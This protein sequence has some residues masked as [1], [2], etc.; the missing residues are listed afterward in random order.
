MD[1][2]YS[3]QN[4]YLNND[5]INMTMARDGFFEFSVNTINKTIAFYLML[6]YNTTE[7]YYGMNT[8]GVVKH[9]AVLHSQKYT[10]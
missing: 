7:A 5:N 9:C 4:K 3:S 2:H 6:Q 1:I 10:G 8:E